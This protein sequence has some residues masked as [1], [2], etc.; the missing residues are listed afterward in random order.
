MA[1]QHL[2]RMFSPVSWGLK[3]KESVF[4]IRPYP[5]AHPLKLGMAIT[6]ILKK[7]D[8]AKTTREAKKIL[9]QK[10]IL[11]DGRRVKDTKFC[12]GFMDIL[13]LK[14]IKEDFRILLDE[15]GRLVPIK[16]SD[17]E[18]SQKLCKLIGKSK[19]KGGKIQLNFSD[20]RNLLVD[21]EDYKVGDSLLLEVPSQ[22]ILQHFPLAKNMTIYL[23]G[24]KH[25][26]TV[27]IIEEIQNEN[28]IIKDKQNNKIETSK[29]FAFVIGKEKEV[30]SLQ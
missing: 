22:K 27:G 12:I 7:L 24:G 15:K 1:K 28:I 6:L 5:G 30:I 18:K 10:E 3:K 11:V 20:S 4:V 21:K 14:D 16:I 26:G 13:S 25:R 19:V 17:K 29:Q 9:T 2:K 23:V 8:L